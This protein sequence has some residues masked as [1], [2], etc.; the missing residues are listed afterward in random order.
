M[1]NNAAQ[2]LQ[3]NKKQYYVSALLPKV[4]RNSSSVTSQ[5]RARRENEGR[6]ASRIRFSCRKL[7]E[8]HK[9]KCIGNLFRATPHA[10]VVFELRSFNFPS[11]SLL[12]FFM[13]SVL[14]CV[15]RRERE[16][17]RET[18][19]SCV[20]KKRTTFTLLQQARNAPS[21]DSF[22]PAYSHTTLTG[23]TMMSH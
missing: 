2:I 11:E 17:E 14:P 20:S 9:S 1:N 21:K 13:P 18:R 23:C 15:T 22:L 16:R 3:I 4:A 10:V 6:A 5:P 19:G 7:S 8:T 12:L